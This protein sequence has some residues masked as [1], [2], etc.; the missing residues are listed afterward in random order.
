MHGNLF[1]LSLHILIGV[2]FF[3]TAVRARAYFDRFCARHCKLSEQFLIHWKSFKVR[4]LIYN[5][6]YIFKLKYVRLKRETSLYEL[7]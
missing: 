5:K 4:K 7:L 3:Q 2:I 6:I 1:K